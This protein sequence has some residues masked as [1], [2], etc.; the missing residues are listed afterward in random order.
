[1]AEII[2]NVRHFDEREFTTQIFPSR[3]GA[4]L[5]FNNSGIFYNGINNEEGFV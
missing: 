2:I 1:M 5:V 3:I 4:F